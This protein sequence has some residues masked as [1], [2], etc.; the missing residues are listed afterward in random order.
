MAKRYMTTLRLVAISV[1]AI[2]LWALTAAVALAQEGPKGAPQPPAHKAKGKHLQTVQAFDNPEAVIFSDDGRFVF[3]SNSAEL[4][5]KDKGFHWS[6]KAGFISKL[7]VLPDGTLQMANPK[8][9]TGIT[10][11]LGMAV[12]PVATRTFPKGTIFLCSGGLP[13]ADAAGNDIKDP[14][15]LTSKL[16]GF[17]IDGKILG[18][19]P[20]N[21]GSALAKISGA[22]GTLPNAAG[23]DKEGNLYVADTGIGGATVEPKLDTR[24]GIFMIP[25]DALDDLAA[26]KTPAATPLFISM[27]GAPDGV[28]VSPVDGTIHVNTVGRAGGIDDPNRG[29]MW[30]L[31]KDDFKAGR[32]PNA[33]SSGWGA[34]DGLAFTASGTRFDTQILP[35]N[36]ITVVPHGSDQVMSLEITGLNRDLAGPADIAIYTRADGTSLLVI[37]ELSALTPNNNDNPIVVVLL[38]KEL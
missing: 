7:S 31:T 36:Y 9:L 15:R 16:I 24:P 26:G 28:E 4:G 25:H 13:L 10:A 33:F 19:I 29:G 27:P 2:A 37:P 34:L 12:N 20:W 3:V 5:M 22:P 30:K 38:P 8:L 17:D 1:V 23:F 32:L 35:P 11:P 6:E 21:A 14:S 18:E